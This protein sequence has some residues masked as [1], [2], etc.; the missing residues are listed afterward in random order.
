[1]WDGLRF[2]LIPAAHH[3]GWL[4]SLGKLA[5][6]EEVQQSRSISLHEGVFRE[7]SLQQEWPPASQERAGEASHPALSPSL[8]TQTQAKRS[9][10][11]R[12]SGRPPMGESHVATSWA[13]TPELKRQVTLVDFGMPI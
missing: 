2:A 4:R 12:D 11:R 8:R 9:G 13:Y 1:M 3:L 10:G 6:R 7:T 5:E